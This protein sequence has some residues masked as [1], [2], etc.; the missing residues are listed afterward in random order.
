MQPVKMVKGESKRLTREHTAYVQWM[1]TKCVHAVT[2]AFDPATICE[3]KR[4]EKDGT[5]VNFACPLTVVQYVRRMGS[6]DSFARELRNEKTHSKS[7]S[8]K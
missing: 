6:A 1:D 8:R 3:V 4:K 7:G 5:L 2:T